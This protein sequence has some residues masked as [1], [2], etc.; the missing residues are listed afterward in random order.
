[1]SERRF[2]VHYDG[3]ALWIILWVILFFPIA[4]T[5]FLTAAVFEVSGTRYQMRYDGSRFW[6]CFWV[7]FFFPIA[8]VLLFINGLSVSTENAN[9]AVVTNVS[10]GPQIQDP[11]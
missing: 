2:K 11:R 1:M 10:P 6:L 9:Q 8:F 3:S 7:L 4:L 5:L